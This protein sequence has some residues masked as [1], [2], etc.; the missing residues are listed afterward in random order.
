MLS[1]AT[2]NRSHQKLKPFRNPLW[3]SKKRAT[4]VTGSR[5]G[6]FRV[7][8]RNCCRIDPMKVYEDASCCREG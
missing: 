8:W 5:E 7:R 4:K 6:L 1:I 3:R 2:A